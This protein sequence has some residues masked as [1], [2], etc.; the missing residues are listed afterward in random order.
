MKKYVFSI[1]IMVVIFSCK[2]DVKPIIKTNGV[3]DSSSAGINIAI[4]ASVIKNDISKQ[5]KGIN[6]TENWENQTYWNYPTAPATSI[7]NLNATII[8][9]GSDDIFWADSPYTAPTPRLIYYGKN[10]Y[11]S[12]QTDIVESDGIHLKSRFLNFDD[13]V[14]LCKSSGCEPEIIIPYNKIYYTPLTGDNTNTKEDFLKNAETLVYYANKI[15]AYNIKYWEIGNESWQSSTNVTAANYGNDLVQFSQRMKAVDPTIKIIANG[16]TESWFQTVLSKANT[17]IDYINVSYYPIYSYTGFDYYLSNN[18]NYGTDAPV[19]YALQALNSTSN[20]G[21]IK[22][23]ITEFNGISFGGPWADKNDLGH[24]LVSFQ[25]GAD[26]MNN[27][28]VFFSSFWNLRWYYGYQPNGAHWLPTDT[29]PKTTFNAADNQGNLNPN[30][31][32]LSLLYSNV[33]GAMVDAESDNQLIRTYAC[34]DKA[35]GKMSIFLI[36]K[37]HISHNVKVSLKN[38]SKST[39]HISVFTGKSD[40]DTQPILTQL[41]DVNFS[42]NSTTLNLS[43]VSIT[44]IQL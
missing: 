27:P 37:D 42:N 7:K 15:K 9:A 14:A 11:L 26:L 23:I 39:G 17:S 32:S 34:V 1:L 5:Y 6:I 2:K 25:M 3:T 33:F 20:T 10:E 44:V 13:F 40:T 29:D 36:N 35:T 28:N 19:N 24:S 16:N 4:D 38:I 30:G 43:A 18:I 22:L 31:Q 41:S 21:K 8:R 12:Y